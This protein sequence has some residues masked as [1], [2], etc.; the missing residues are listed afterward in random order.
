MTE[1]PSGSDLAWVG[2]QALLFALVAV[3]AVL[4]G[5]WRVPTSL[6]GALVLVITGAAVVVWTSRELGRALTP[7]P[8]PNGAGLVARGPYRWVRHP[9]YAALVVI[10]LGVAVGSGAVI[11]Y[12]AVVALAAFFAAKARREEAGLLVAYEGYA[13]YAAQTGRLVPGIGR[14]R[15][16]APRR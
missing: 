7:M 15:M 8:T 14:L 1:S 2:A 16:D 9:M 3:T 11:S 12:V 6:A 10:C 4:G 5:P 13:A